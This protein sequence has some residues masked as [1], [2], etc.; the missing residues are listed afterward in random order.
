MYAHR[1]S[2]TVRQR[3]SGRHTTDVPAADR[4]TQL[5]QT[6]GNRAVTALIQR[7]A[8]DDAEAGRIAGLKAKFLATIAIGAWSK[9]A[10]DLNA[11]SDAD[12]AVMVALPGHD[13]LI[14]LDATARRT[15]PDWSARVTNAIAAHD[16]EADRVGKLTADYE[17][18]VAD[19]DIQAAAIALN[20]FSEHD[21][22][23]KGSKLDPYTL[24]MMRYISI[25]LYG[26]AG[27]LPTLLVAVT[28]QVEPFKFDENV[29]GNAYTTKGSFDYHINGDAIVVDVGMD[30]H[31]D[32]GVTVPTGTWFGY[33][34][35]TWNRFSAVNDADP[36]DRKH[37]DFNP[38]AGQGHDIKV[39]T[40]DAGDATHPS[41]RANAGH[42]YAGDPRSDVA[43]PHEFGHLM[44]LED[45]YERD[46]GDY[47]RV[48]GNAPTVG[49]TRAEPSGP[50]APPAMIAIEIHNG[51]FIE[52]KFFQWHK[53]AEHNRMEA[54]DYALS[55]NNITPAYDGGENPL[56][57]SIAV[58]YKRIYGHD[59]ADD[60]KSQ[61]DSNGDDF[62][63]WRERVLG[64]FESTSDSIMGDMSDH[65]HPVAA[66]HVRKFADYVQKSL[67]RGTWSAKEVR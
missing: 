10:S 27:R 5:Q 21:I 35:S 67:G 40:Y 66:R 65:T 59:M 41:S 38:I 63:D 50:H 1:I 8:A 12:L 18:A 17:T 43:V 52:E 3:A 47:Q 2:P 34:T 30:F 60:V 61:V 16:A 48:T 51:L 26:A 37:I 64:S 11:M 62:R 19:H 36:N 7:D 31:P 24:A 22:L 53:T 57:T 42:Y 55:A 39:S 23:D 15:A 4:L 25:R 29:G 13:V 45:E 58:E 9:A 28:G 49:A 56:T 33:V 20:G 44:G 32:D 54:V 14:R 6:A 46:P